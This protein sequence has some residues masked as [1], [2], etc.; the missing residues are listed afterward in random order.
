MGKKSKSRPSEG[1]ESVKTDDTT[2]ATAT[3]TNAASKPSFLA[4][5]APIDPTLASLFEKSVRS[6]IF[7]KL[8]AHL[9][10]FFCVCD[11]LDCLARISALIMLC[12]LLYR[13][14]P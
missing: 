13:P 7:F 8:S 5:D 1:A 14:V 6:R 11:C 3:T 4:G 10:Y 9:L 12:Y 2:A